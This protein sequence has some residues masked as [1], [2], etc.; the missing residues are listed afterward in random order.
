MAPTKVWA[1][2]VSSSEM[3]VTWEPVQQDTNGILLGY[4]VSTALGRGA[5]GTSELTS[6]SS[7]DYSF[8]EVGDCCRRAALGR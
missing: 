3:N 4:E 7:W 6:H 2:G 8:T 1:K 5:R